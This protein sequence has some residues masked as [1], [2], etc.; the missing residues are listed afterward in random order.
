M[1]R[2]TLLVLVVMSML[3]HAQ[4]TQIIPRDGNRS[5]TMEQLL[6]NLNFSEVT[7]NYLLD[8]GLQLE[9]IRIFDGHEITD[10]N[11]LNINRF[12]RLYASMNNAVIRS[13]GLLPSPTTSYRRRLKNLSDSDA[14][15]IAILDVNYHQFKSYA[16]DSNLISERSNQFYDVPDRRESPYEEKA[17]FAGSALKNHISSATP[18][19]T[20]ASDLY[21]SNTGATISSI[22]IDFADGQGAQTV[23]MDAPIRAN[24]TEVG[25]KKVE[26][27]I[28]FTDRQRKR[29]HFVVEIK[30]LSDTASGRF[31]DV[32][33]FSETI[34]ADA[35]DTIDAD[36]DGTDDAL[37]SATISFFS[38]CEDISVRKPLIYIEGFDPMIS[39][40]TDYVNIEERLTGFTTTAG[41]ISLQ[42]HLDNSG[43]DIIY[44]DFTDGTDYIERNAMVVKNV[45]RR[46]N[47]LK[48]EYGSAHKNVV[49]GNSMGGLVG[50]YALLDFEQDGEDHET[51][52]LL[53]HDSPFIG[54][55]VPLSV[56][57]M[58]DQIIN[59]STP[60]PNG[61]SVSWEWPFVDLD[62]APLKDFVVELDNTD[63][64]LRSPAA[65][66]QLLYHIYSD[67]TLHE[68]FYADL[69]AK[70]AP[71][72]FEHVSIS[73]G[74]ILDDVTTT[75]IDERSQIISPGELMFEID[76]ELISEAYSAIANQ[77]DIPSWI[78]FHTAFALQAT[79]GIQ[80]NVEIKLWALPDDPDDYED[81]Y[82]GDIQ[83]VVLHHVVSESYKHVRVRGTQ[84]YDSAPGG[85]LGADVSSGF[86]PDLMDAGFP[87]TI[88]SSSFCHSPAVG[89]TGLQAPENSDLFFDLSAPEQVVEDGL[90]V[91][92]RYTGATLDSSWYGVSQ[93]NSPHVSFSATNAAFYLSELAAGF[94]IDLSTDLAATY[95]FGKSSLPPTILAPFLETPDFID[96][97]VILSNGVELWINRQD[98]IATVSD[99][100]N[101]QNATF[102]HFDVYTQTDGCDDENEFILIRINNSSKII[103]GE[104][105]GAAGNTGALHLSRGTRLF[106][107]SNGLLEIDDN[108][109]LVV[110]NGA[111]V[112]VEAGGLLNPTWHS[113]VIVEAGGTLRIKA[114]G[115]LRASHMAQV[116]VQPGGQLILEDGAI[117]QMWDGDG[118]STD[119]RCRITFGGTVVDPDNTPDVAELVIEGEFEWQ[120]SGFMHILPNM[121]MELVADADFKLDGYGKGIRF[122]KIAGTTLRIPKNQCRL[123]NGKVEYVGNGSIALET[124]ASARFYKTVFEGNENATAVS[125]IKSRYVFANQCDFLDF[126]TAIHGELISETFL[127]SEVQVFD[128]L[129]QN[130]RT[131]IF[132]EEFSNVRVNNSSIVQ[133]DILNTAVGIHLTNVDNSYLTNSSILNTHRGVQLWGASDFVMHGGIIDGGSLIQGR[134]GINVND[135]YHEGQANT[136][137]DLTGQATISHHYFGIFILPDSEMTSSNFIP[138]LVTLDCARIIDNAIGIRGQDFLLNMD[139][140][141]ETASNHLAVNTSFGSYSKLIEICYHNL[142]VIE[143]A[144][145]NNYWEGN[146]INRKI[147]NLGTGLPQGC[148]FLIDDDIGGNT[149]LGDVIFLTDPVLSS[150][151]EDCSSPGGSPDPGNDDRVPQIPT[152]E[153]TTRVEECQDSRRNPIYDA[154]WDA[155]NQYVNE[156]TEESP[157]HARSKAMFGEIARIDDREMA[158]FSETCKAL[159]HQS[160]SRAGLATSQTPRKDLTLNSSNSVGDAM[161]YP[162]PLKDEL[163][164]KMGN[165]RFVGYKVVDLMGRYWMEGQIDE[166]TITAQIDV[167]SLP[168]GVFILHLQNE[169]ACWKTIRFVVRE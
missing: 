67:G 114:G 11:L 165:D 122:L 133:T 113:Q 112:T 31:S 91:V 102:T 119:G 141:S 46:V 69:N 160:R 138:P 73:N 86:I 21:Y 152:D 64:A 10:G 80:A 7:S 92:D 51:E 105:V 8:K 56:Q 5:L 82:L 57:Y 149:G 100:T 59:L 75:S 53:T 107:G 87:I 66:Q 83:I 4:D 144:A 130:C 93:R 71:Q 49:I 1:K 88:N 70:P 63:K 41:G 121:N 18:T 15:P 99:T 117:V 110:K 6:G 24:Y 156:C 19:F 163:S 128:C 134:V 106:V 85:M 143:I 95:N 158:S 132:G 131:S 40:N 96:E 37:G 28:T 155:Y 166:E 61:I 3:C 129:F 137:V 32:P 161:I 147:Y 81:S 145:T 164:L 125:A 97:D 50:K 101:P 142:N 16:L 104:W 13:D 124:E 136:T 30:R 48:R 140:A 108:S 23:L 162:N 45:I 139:A 169:A 123:L 76:G 43:Y 127:G 14:I 68:E 2:L 94:P 27:E 79:L 42:D 146:N 35:A 77:Y 118:P 74:A 44:V 9:P 22:T 55:N 78:V 39:E 33:N 120:G 29:A 115:T 12:G 62:F 36:G 17:L 20:F 60:V 126:K 168:S 153:F 26:F 34:F 159:I 98:R 150:I 109:K 58:A 116:W 25:T 135:S 167:S 157:S 154:Y 84:P 148:T 103:I 38:Q 111:E 90:T 54:S 65:Q 89:A 47:E 151:P 72:F 52:K